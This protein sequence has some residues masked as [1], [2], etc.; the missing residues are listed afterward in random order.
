MMERTGKIT[1]GLA[2]VRWTNKADLQDKL[3][4]TKLKSVLG[5]ACHFM[6]SVLCLGAVV[7]ICANAPAQNLFVSV[8]G[9]D[10]NIYEL[11]PEGVRTI[12][13]SEIGIAGALAFDNAGNLFVASDNIY[14]FSPD[15]MRSTF[16]TGIFEAL[17]F[18]KAGNL[19]VADSPGYAIYKFT[20]G[21]MR[22]TFAATDGVNRIAFQP[23]QGSPPPQIVATPSV[24]PDGGEFRRRVMV[25]LTDVTPGTTIYYT[26]DGSDPTTTSLPYLGAFRLRHSATVKTIA[27]DSSGNEGAIKIHVD[28][29]SIGAVYWQFTQIANQLQAQ[30]DS[31]TADAFRTYAMSFLSYAN[32][33]FR[34]TS[35]RSCSDAG[36]SEWT[37]S[38]SG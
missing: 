2:I 23:T 18:D 12:F 13:A 28:F 22:S 27:V 10:A 20:P 5:R 16:A 3:T 8:D 7:L 21:G 30:G 36:S 14:E 24:S 1:D 17:A 37:D 29:P 33:S 38:P 9:P 35:A 4:E 32:R 26:L 25:T 11:T 6:S 15:G 19:F 31:G 34:V